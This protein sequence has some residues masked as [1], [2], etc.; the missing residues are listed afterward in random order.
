LVEWIG[1]LEVKPTRI[2]REDPLAVRYSMN[3]VSFT[4]MNS[5]VHVILG[6]GAGG[7]ET[8]TAILRDLIEI[9][10]KLVE[11]KV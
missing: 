9:K 4:T 5:G 6:R 1:G 3:A 7:R 11:V 10:K 2:K 8:A